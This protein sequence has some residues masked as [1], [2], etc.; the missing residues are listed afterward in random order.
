MLA[1]DLLDPLRFTD[2]DTMVSRKKLQTHYGIRD[3]GASLT[4]SFSG[5]KCHVGTQQKARRDNS[6]R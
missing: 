6:H 4:E 5:R 2:V 1:H 3:V